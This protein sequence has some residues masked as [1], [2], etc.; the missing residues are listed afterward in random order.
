MVILFFD[1]LLYQFILYTFTW[2]NL[3]DKNQ[4]YLLYLLLNIAHQDHELFTCNFI[5]TEEPENIIP[6]YLRS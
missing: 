3:I 1:E 6:S 5:S 4:S 2:F